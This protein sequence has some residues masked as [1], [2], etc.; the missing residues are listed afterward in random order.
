M[1]KYWNTLIWLL[2]AVAQAD[3]FVLRDPVILDSVSGYIGNPTRL[4]I[5][6]HAVY[7]I[8][9]DQNGASVRFDAGKADLGIGGIKWGE[10]GDKPC[11][12]RLLPQY[13]NTIFPAGRTV[14]PLGG[15]VKTRNICPGQGRAGDFLTVRAKANNNQ[16]AFV[17]GISVCV[18]KRKDSSKSR[19]KGIRL[20][21]VTLHETAP[22][23]RAVDA[24]PE[25]NAQPHCKDNWQEAVFCP[26]GFIATGLR[27]F[28]N[29]TEPSARGLSLRCKRV[30]RDVSYRGTSTPLSTP[31]FK[32][33]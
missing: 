31:V 4:N 18:T 11:E 30:V 27:I 14:E 26:A 9:E 15:L 5:G 21:G 28:E 19:L 13:L 3:F 22:L 25:H 1:Y 2:P 17:N 7:S 10:R 16:V 6:R 33:K 20:Y 24:S 32:N 29:P 8:G 23:V 12:F